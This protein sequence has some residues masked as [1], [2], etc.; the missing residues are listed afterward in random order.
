MY[1]LFRLRFVSRLSRLIPAFCCYYFF[2][3]ICN[4]IHLLLYC[5][6][7]KTLLAIQTNLRVPAVAGAFLKRGSAILITIAGS[8]TR[9]MNTKDVQIKSVASMSLLVPAKCAFLWILCVTATTTAGTDQMKEIAKKCVQTL[10]TTFSAPPTTSAFR[11]LLCATASPSAV[12]ERTK[13]IVPTCKLASIRVNLR[14]LTVKMVRTF[15]I[16]KFLISYSLW[17]T[18]L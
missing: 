6:G 7:V 4:L 1:S 13:G 14:S 8:A 9:A 17:L 16:T 11:L 10:R 2:T 18:S 12:A 5:S 15:K 3:L